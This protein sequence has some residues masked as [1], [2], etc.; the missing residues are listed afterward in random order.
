MKFLSLI[1]LT[2]LTACNGNQTPPEI[3]TVDWQT[4]HDAAL[5]ASAKTGK[6]VFLLFQEVP[7]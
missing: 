6:P 2:I 3:G 1:F 5:A 4:D 7:G